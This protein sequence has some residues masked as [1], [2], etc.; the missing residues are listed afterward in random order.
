MAAG[1]DRVKL[2]PT[3]TSYLELGGSIT[4]QRGPE[5]WAEAGWHPVAPLS[6]FGRAYANSQDAGA[7][8]GARVSW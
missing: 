1:L 8:V 3:G 6:V 7:M 4:K 5:A 2:L